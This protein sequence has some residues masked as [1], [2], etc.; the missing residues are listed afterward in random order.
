[1]VNVSE[2]PEVHFKYIQAATRTG[3]IREVERICRESNHYNPEKV[4]N[5]LK[6]AKLADQLPLI[7]VCDRFDFVHDLVLYLYQ[8]G[9]IKSIEVHVQRVNSVR[10]PQARVLAGSQDTAG[11]NA[12]AKIYIDSNNNPEAFLKENN[13]LFVRKQEVW[14]RLAQAQ[15][16]GL[17]IKDAIDS[18]IKAE[19]A[20]NFMQARRPHR[21]ATRHGGLL[22]GM[23]NVADILEVGEKCFNDELYQAVKLLFASIPNWDRL[24]TT[25][26]YLGENQ[27]AVDSARKA[28]NTHLHR[29]IR[30]H[31]GGDLWVIHTE[32]LAAIVQLYEHCEHFEEVISLLKAGLGLERVHMGIFTE[33]AI[34]LSSLRNFTDWGAVM[35]HLKVY[36]SCINIPKVVKAAEKAHLWPELGLFYIKYNKFDNAAV[37][38]IEWSADAWEHNQFKNVVVWVANIE[39]Y[40]R[41]LSFCLEE[42]PNLLTDLLTVLIPR[43]NHIQ[44]T[45][46]AGCSPLLL[47][48]EDV[49]DAYNDLLI[50]EEDYKSLSDSIDNFNTSNTITLAKC[51]QTSLLEFRRLAAPPFQALLKQ[52]Q[53]YK[54]TM[55]TVSMSGLTEV[56]EELLSYFVDIGNKEYFSAL[57]FICFNLLR[58]DVVKELSW[59]HGLNYFYMPYKIQV[60]HSLVTKLAQL[61]KEVKEQSKKDVQKEEVDTES[62]II[63]PGLM[64][65]N[66]P[67]GYT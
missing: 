33:M 48:L 65:T 37:A 19:D 9:K 13:I 3:Q 55:I 18:Y 64:I 20:T 35:E 25:L 12:I 42:Q 49:N 5:F 23:T 1:M 56:A 58:S 39:S 21:P 15:L 31:S 57:L 40:Y 29:E 4:K 53:L 17:G 66:G 36:V 28:G 38:M 44:A 32:E 24:A 16:D 22:G 11:F 7:I 14:S 54:D 61:E 52:D 43:I 50:E 2:D 26:I 34:L 8:N 67:T 51:L 41:T 60:Q 46:L 63:N 27:A 59:Q 45:S 10:T 30:F 6:E 47:N 62:R